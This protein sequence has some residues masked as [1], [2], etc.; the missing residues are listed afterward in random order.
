MEKTIGFHSLVCP[1]CEANL[2]IDDG[3]LTYICPYCGARI[4]LKGLSDGELEAKVNMAELEYKKY[5]LRHK[6]IEKEKEYQRKRRSEIEDAQ[7]ML[8]GSIALIVIIVLIC[9]IFFFSEVI[10]DI[11]TRTVSVPLS[12]SDLLK[13]NHSEVHDVL[14]KAGFK[15]IDEIPI[16]GKPGLFSKSDISSISIN[17]KTS[18]I[19]GTTFPQ[20]AT[21]IITYYSKQEG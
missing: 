19:E 6:A 2:K 3:L 12:S 13:L 8:I 21:I 16:D 4:L 15:K 10:G 1:N 7:S 9:G 18:F 5:E 14:S 11:A 20:K 17:G